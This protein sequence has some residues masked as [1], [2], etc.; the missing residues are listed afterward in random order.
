MLESVKVEFVGIDAG[1]TAVLFHH[2]IEA[3]PADRQII[4][5]RKKNRGIRSAGFEVRFDQAHF[6]GLHGMGC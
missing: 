3:L 4:P 5:A 1:E 6:I 2:L